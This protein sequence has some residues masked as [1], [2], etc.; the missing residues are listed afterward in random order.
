MATYNNG[1]KSYGL[2][3]KKKGLG[4]CK[5]KYGKEISLMIT[6]PLNKLFVFILVVK[7]HK[8]VS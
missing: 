6:T 1:V 2:S 8:R 3:A 5:L 7:Y 4:K